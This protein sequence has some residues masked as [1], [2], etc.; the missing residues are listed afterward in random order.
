M[1]EEPTA[2]RQRNPVARAIDV[3]GWIADHQGESWGVRQMARDLEVFPSTVHRILQTFVNGGLLGK[4]ELGGYVVGAELYRICQS[5][6]GGLSPLKIARPH[7]EALAHK[8][9]ETILLGMYLPKR[10]LMVYADIVPAPHPL[11]YVVE[12]NLPRPVYAGATGLAIFAFLPEKERQEIYKQGLQAL[13]DSTVTEP[14]ELEIE[15]A[16]IRAQGY[17]RTKGQRT[18]GAV[19]VAAPIFD[20]FGRVF[21]DVC[22]TIPDQR[23]EDENEKYLSKVLKETARE[24]SEEL[25]RSGYRSG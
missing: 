11:R 2:S 7:L 10:H 21:G 18:V 3:L 9:G 20:S 22:I 16:H 1:K 17:A 14:E 5:L 25:K 4:D 24:L 6:V 13:T 12:L 15:L 19:G 23:F 8:V